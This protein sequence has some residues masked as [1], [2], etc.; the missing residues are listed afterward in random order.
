MKKWLA[1]LLL[2]L[3]TA[4]GS[5]AWAEPAIPPAPTSSIY[6]QDYAGVLTP[7]TKKRINDLGG[8]LAARTKAQIVVVTVQTLGDTPLEE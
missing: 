5:V 7:D 3:Y 6:V 1:W 8:K 4:L 2:I